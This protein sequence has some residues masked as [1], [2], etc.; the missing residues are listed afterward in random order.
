[1]GNVLYQ[2]S[3]SQVANGSLLLWKKIH[4]SFKHSSSSSPS[5]TPTTLLDHG[6]IGIFT[7]SALLEMRTLMKRCHS[8]IDMQRIGLLWSLVGCCGPE[9]LTP[10]TFDRV[11]LCRGQ[12]NLH[13]WPRDAPGN[14]SPLQG[15]WFPPLQ[16]SPKTTARQWIFLALWKKCIGPNLTESHSAFDKLIPSE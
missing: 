13:D 3:Q 16:L 10:N 9:R 1:M 8:K 12:T 4:Q 6:L 15:T 2:S 14:I 11:V 5:A 7:A